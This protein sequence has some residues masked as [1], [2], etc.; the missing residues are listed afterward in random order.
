MGNRTSTALT[1]IVPDHALSPCARMIKA[2]GVRL[3]V[4]RFEGCLLRKNADLTNVVP[5]YTDHARKQAVRRYADQLSND[6]VLLMNALVTYG[7][8]VAVLTD[9]SD[10]KNGHASKDGFVFQGQPLVR[11]VLA[12]HDLIGPDI[13]KHIHVFHGPSTAYPGVLRVYKFRPQEI[14]VIDDRIQAVQHARAKHMM[15]LLVENH[16]VGLELL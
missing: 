11:A 16:M 4:F 3:V 15:A 14:L 1:Q 2:M 10:H 6:A 13:A 12:D 8:P 9:H 7:L 5:T